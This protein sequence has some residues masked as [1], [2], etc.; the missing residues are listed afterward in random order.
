MPTYAKF[1]KDLRTKKWK[2]SEEIVTLDVGCSAIIPKCLHKKIKDPCSFTKPVFLVDFVIIDIEE[3]TEVPI[4]L[5]RPFIKTDRVIIDMDYGKLKVKVQDQEVN[6][7]VFE[8]MQHPKNKQH[9]FRVDV[10]EELYMLDDIHLSRS[11]PLE[12][13]DGGKK[14][15]IISNT[16]SYVEEKQLI[17]MLK[18]NA[19]A[20]GWTLSDLHGISP[21]YCMHKIHMEQDYRLAT[22]KDHFPLSFKD[23]M[24]ER[25]AG[26]T[27]YYFLDGYSGYNKITVDPDDQTKTTFTCHFGI[28]T[29]RKM[30]SRLCNAPTTFQRCMLAIYSDLCHFMVTEGVVLGHE[31]SSRGIE[32]DKAKIKVIKELLPSLIKDFSLV[33]QEFDFVIKDSKGSENCVAGHLSR[34]ANQ[35]VTEREAN[36]V[37]E[38]PHEKLL[39]IQEKAMEIEVFNCWG[40]DF[41][42]PFPPFHSHLYILVVVDYVS[43]WVEAIVSSRDDSKTVVKFLKINISNRFGTP[44]ALI[45]NGSSHFCNS[46]LEKVLQ[47]YGVQ[48]KVSSPYHPQTN[49]QVE[50]SNR[51]INGILEK[52]VSRTRNDWS[53]RLDDA[54][55][56]YMMVFKAPTGLSPYQLVY[57]IACHLPVE[58]GHK[59]F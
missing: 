50:V 10:I 21:S 29:C 16:L 6:F 34:L 20:I 22:R 27:F 48:H 15:I 43:K 13:E 40:I 7:N 55:W 57:G 17:Y 3:D 24:I 30:S 4:I 1:M 12:K 19:G 39:M 14:L 23:Q 52:T 31:I 45:S 36:V 51:E 41:M 44:R 58:L 2:F 5:G 11:S 37:E 35:E 18:K 38:F 25:L 53:L 42:G 46:Q 33:M 59:E 26:Q 47:H 9:C 54:L 28:F 8:A 49:R 56:A 32:V